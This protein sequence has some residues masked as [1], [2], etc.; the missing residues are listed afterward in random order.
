MAVRVRRSLGNQPA[1]QFIVGTAIANYLRLVHLTGRYVYDPP[2]FLARTKA[3][4]PVIFAMW[5]GEH[6]L[7]APIN[8]GRFPSDALI[9]RHRDGAINAIAARQFGIGSIRGSGAHNTDFHRKGGVPAFREMLNALKQ[10][11]S[12]G[13]TADVPKVARVVGKGI[14]RLAAHSG[15]PIYPVAIASRFRRRL[16]TWDKT[17]INLPFSRIAV[18]GGEMI[19]VA[20]DS[21]EDSLEKT[22][23]AVQTA[24]EETTARAYA[25][26][27]GT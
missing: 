8:G 15:R 4:L 7:S 17:V 3:E 13:M 9:S 21:D 25:L 27:D 18:A 10:G 23:L 5:H 2:D 14:V 12:I 11:R 20:A 26:A 16:D 24:L 1:V 6:L 22:R 19:Y